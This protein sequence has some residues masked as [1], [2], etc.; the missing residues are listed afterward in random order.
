MLKSGSTLV[1]AGYDQD[2]ASQTSQGVGNAYNYL[3][4]GG[5][6]NQRQR[7]ILFLAM[8]P[9]EITLPRMENE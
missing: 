9:Q 3:L 1:L 8:T 6:G 7:Q 4:G 2:Q 5:V